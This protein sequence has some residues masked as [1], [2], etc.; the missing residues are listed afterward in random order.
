MRQK[1][2]RV[3]F[4]NGYKVTV[5][6]EDIHDIDG[7][8]EQGQVEE[9]ARNILHEAPTFDHLDFDE[10]EKMNVVKVDPIE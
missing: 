1:A 7:Q 10:V 5:E 2:W 3:Y 4:D 6:R 9:T 8:V